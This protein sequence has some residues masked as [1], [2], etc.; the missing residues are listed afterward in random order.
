M[1]YFLVA[2]YLQTLPDV[3]DESIGL[4]YE[5]CVFFIS[6]DGGCWLVGWTEMP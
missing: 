2:G 5:G 4:I 1:V 6:P 3:S